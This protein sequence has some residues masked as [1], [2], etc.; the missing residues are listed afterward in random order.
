MKAYTDIDLPIR[1][2]G[3]M[4]PSSTGNPENALLTS[5][6]IVVTFLGSRGNE[7]S[8][9]AEVLSSEDMTIDDTNDIILVHL[10]PD[11][12]ALLGAGQ[13][14]IEVTL[15]LHDGMVAKTRTAKI[16]LADAVKKEVL[17]YVG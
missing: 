8:K 9:L 2:K 10:T 1:L 11:E 6:A 13:V 3:I 14:A 5:Q 7:V 4:L 12:T 15:V 16:N 17:S